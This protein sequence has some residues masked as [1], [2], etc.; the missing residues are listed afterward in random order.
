VI[1]EAV[2]KALGDAKVRPRTA[3]ELAAARKSG[4]DLVLP[5]P[6]LEELAAGQ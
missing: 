4:Q 5:L 1:V 3:K 2:A 6:Q